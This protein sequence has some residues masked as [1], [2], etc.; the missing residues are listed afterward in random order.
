MLDKTTKKGLYKFRRVTN[1]VD[2][3]LTKKW[4][5]STKLTKYLPE[6]TF[7][8]IQITDVTTTRLFLRGRRSRFF[9]TSNND[10]EKQ[11]LSVI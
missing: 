1:N 5:R 8:G 3:N 2:R 9:D 11:T 6:V 4:L 7:I 10:T